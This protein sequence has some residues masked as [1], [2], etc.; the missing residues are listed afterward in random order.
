VVNNENCNENK[1]MALTVNNKKE[2]ID[3]NENATKMS[4]EISGYN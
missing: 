1:T 3:D 4:N 2:L